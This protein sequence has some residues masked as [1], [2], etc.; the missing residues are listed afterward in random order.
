MTVSWSTPEIHSAAQTP[1]QMNIARKWCVVALLGLGIMVANLDRLNLSVVLALAE[2]RNAFHLT[3]LDRG[4]LNSTFFWTYAFLQVPAGWLVDRFGVK[5]PYSIGF[6][7]WCVISAAT[8]M[9]STLWQIV[10]IRLL[11]GVGE[12]IVQPAS[13][14]WIRF[15]FEEKKRTLPVAVYLLGV[16]LGSAIG[17]PLAVVLIAAFHWRVMFVI[18]GLGGLIWV[19]LWLLLVPNDDREI[20]RVSV[21]KSASVAGTFGRVL[22]SPT[23][24]GICIGTFSYNYFFYFCLTWLPSYFVEQHQL[25]MAGMGRYMF[26]CALG[27]AVV[28][29]ASGWFSDRLIASGLDPVKVRRR[30]VITGLML[31]STVYIGVLSGSR[32]VGLFFI[33]FSLSALGIA[34]AN[35]WS[36]TQSLFPGAAIGQVI[37]LQNTANNLAGIAAPLVTGW[38]KHVTGGYAAPL[39][40]IS[41]VLLVGV[42]SF[43]V[44]VPKELAPQSELA[45]RGPDGRNLLDGK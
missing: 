2:F 13:L 37:G 21:V 33:V 25:S 22:A 17:A 16:K 42:L 24:W 9:V 40:G 8:G 23:M 1:R 26:F 44:L 4:L 35:K 45:F 38:L 15:H 3:D 39:L 11:L 31:A 30:F 7:L 41:V 28:M 5:Y 36:L 18:L 32:A 20:E 14:R 34:T 27:Q 43:T 19:V 12:A 6:A 10:L 29:A